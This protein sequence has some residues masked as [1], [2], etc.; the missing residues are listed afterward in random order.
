MLKTTTEDLKDEVN[1]QHGLFLAIDNVSH[2]P[3][4]WHLSMLLNYDPVMHEQWHYLSLRKVIG[5][6]A[7][8]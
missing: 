1:S 4:G 8:G 5:T 2:T 6:G 3:R 7:A